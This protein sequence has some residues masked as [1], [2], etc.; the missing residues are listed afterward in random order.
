V[1]NK[2]AFDG[3][4]MKSTEQMDLIK[5]ANTRFAYCDSLIALDCGVVL[6]KH[7]QEGEV[8]SVD[9]ESGEL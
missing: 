1:V 8:F 9:L 6:A 4:I 5:V 3:P 2:T 7:N